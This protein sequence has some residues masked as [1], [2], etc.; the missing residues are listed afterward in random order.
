MENNLITLE[1]MAAISAYEIG[2]IQIK[3]QPMVS[4]IMLAYNHAEYIRQAIYSIVKQQTEGFT[5][6]LLIGEDGS[7]DNTLDICKE[8][9]QQYPDI[10]RLIISEQNVGMHRNFARLWIR[11]RG[12][13]I[14]FCE[15]DDYWIDEKKLIKQIHLLDKNPECTLCGTYTQSIRQNDQGNWENTELIRPNKVQDFYSFQEM[16]PSY[17]FH[18]SSIML[19]KESV[20]FPTWFWNVYCVDRPLY[21]LATQKGLAGLIPEITSVYRHHAGGGWSPLSLKDK[22]DKSTHLFQTMGEYF[23]KR[24]KG[25]FDKTLGNILWFYMSEAIKNEQFFLS[26]ILFWQSILFMK[27]NF[28]GIT[29]TNLIKIFCKINILGILRN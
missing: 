27:L 9:Q 22:A 10:I 5:F 29:I 26:K 25:F 18:F 8:I 12:K 11:A 28:S 3:A 6:E 4:V 1:M 14:A 7:T 15:G 23:N 24:Y 17:N 20:N 2:D 13:Y 16:I 19:A 21:L